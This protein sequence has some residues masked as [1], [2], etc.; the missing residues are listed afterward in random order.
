M[1]PVW[2]SVPIICHRC[3]WLCLQICGNLQLE[4]RQQTLLRLSHF[5]LDNLSA[6]SKGTE[7]SWRL[8]RL[9]VK[10][11]YQKSSPRHWLSIL[12]FYIAPLPIL[13]R[14]KTKPQLVLCSPLE[15]R[16]LYKAITAR[17][18]LSQD[19]RGG[20]YL[21][22]ISAPLPLI[23]IYQMRPFLARWTVS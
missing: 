2:L 5:L 18:G 11:D 3:R 1:L 16:I 8:F 15:I 19:Q 21:L 4:K 17:D 23:K 12:N 14:W 10:D 22:K 6:I 20:R 13:V 7:H 9:K